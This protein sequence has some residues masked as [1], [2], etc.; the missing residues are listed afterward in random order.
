MFVFFE[1]TV[2]LLCSES[3]EAELEEAAE[4]TKIATLI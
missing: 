3:E 2:F 4:S 1:I